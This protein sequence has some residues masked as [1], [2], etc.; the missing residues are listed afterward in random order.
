MAKQYVIIQDADGSILLK[1]RGP[2]G[3]MRNVHKNNGDKVGSFNSQAHAEKYVQDREA[4]KR[5][6]IRK[7]RAAVDQSGIRYVF[8]SA[9][10]EDLTIN[11]KFRVIRSSKVEERPFSLQEYT[12]VGWVDVAQKVETS[13][14]RRKRKT[15]S[16]ESEAKTE[17]L[18]I[19]QKMQ[20]QADRRK[21]AR[22]LTVI[23]SR[24]FDHTE[25]NQ[26]AKS[27]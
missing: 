12:S 25:E 8:D 2:F 19:V 14:W 3:L 17:L 4:E 1:V 11:V 22:I 20:E 16:S 21:H 15:F 5:E 6:A 27:V 10:D 23:D 18:A 9:N 24:V 7:R 26:I 13:F